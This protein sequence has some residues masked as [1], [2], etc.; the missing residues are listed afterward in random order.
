MPTGRNLLDCTRRQAFQIGALGGFGLTL[1]R[2]LQAESSSPGGV[3]ANTI[4]SCILLFY[5]GGPSHLDTYDM[6]PNAPAKVRGEFSA[7]ALR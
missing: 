6:K 3:K 2:L 5:Y 7:I 4:K 1:P